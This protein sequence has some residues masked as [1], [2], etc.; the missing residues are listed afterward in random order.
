MIILIFEIGYAPAL[1]GMAFL[2]V[3][4]PCQNYFASEI[5]KIRRQ[6]I[7]F[8]DERVK[9]I[10]ESLQAIRVIKL[11]A[12]E[13]PIE[14]RVNSVREK[15]TTF[16][17]KYLDAS[18][19]LRELM[20][21]AQP[22]AA[23]VI[24]TVA[25]YGIDKPLNIVQ[26]FRVLAFLNITRL[27]LNL[28]GQALKNGSDGLVSINRLN[29]F[30]LQRTLPINAERVQV[31]NPSIHL[32]D[33]TFSWQDQVLTSSKSHDHN[34]AEASPT[35]DDKES[36]LDYF[37]LQN[38]SFSNSKPNELIAIVGPVGSGKSSLISSI[39]GEMVKVSGQ[40]RVA[41]TISYCS[42]TPWIQ[43]LTL[44]Q[45][46]L[47]EIQEKDMNEE[48][49]NKYYEATEAAALRPDIKIL[50]AGDK[51]EIGERGINLSGGQKARVSLARAFFAN[52]RSQIYLLDDPFSA[53]D[54]NTG[55]TIFQKGIM[56]LLKNKLRI[57]ALNS[58]MHLLK[59]FDRI[60]VLE[61]GRIVADGSFDVL[62]QA[63][64]ELMT[65]ITGLSYTAKDA[66]AE[67]D[68]KV[69]VAEVAGT[70]A[71]HSEANTISNQMNTMEI[72][73]PT[74]VPTIEGSNIEVIN[75]GESDANKADVKVIPFDIEQGPSSSSTPSQIISSTLNNE[76]KEK[77]STNNIVKKLVQQEKVDSGINTMVAYLKYFSA[78]LVS[79]NS[80]QRHPFYSGE[81]TTNFY[82]TQLLVFG[83]FS[84]L[85]L[86]ILFSSTQFFRIAVDYCIVKFSENFGHYGNYWQRM[87]YSSFGF[88]LFFL[89]LRSVY[90]NFFAVRSSSVLHASV[91]RRVLSAPITTFFDTHTVGAILNRFSKDME[92]VEVNIPE[93]MLQLLINWFQVFSV[94]GL[95]IWASPWF[96]IILIPLALGF[97]RVY[98][99]FSGS[100][101][102]LKRLESVSRSPIYAS[103]SETLTGLETIRAYGDHHRFLQT[104]MKRMQRNQNFMYHLYLC[105]SWMTIR[106]EFSTSMILTSVSLL[107][108]C[109]RE[110]VSPI[111]LGLALSYG[112]QLTAL[113]QRCVQLVI[114]IQTYMTS[115]ERVLEYLDKP[116][117]VNVY[118]NKEYS[119]QKIQF[120][121]QQE[122]RQKQEQQQLT[123]GVSES[124]V[125]WPRSGEIELRNVWMQYR[126]NPPV[127]KGLAAHIKSGE[128]IGVCGRT[129][130]GKVS[131]FFYF[132]G[133]S[134]I[135]F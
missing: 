20:F 64:P 92:T 10:N 108:V 43:N 82:S 133:Q 129:G 104:H 106:L 14:N 61:E 40:C 67:G 63:N 22:V 72:H 57:I 102:D 86:L 31:E 39:L 78:S 84:G 30:L 76:G 101:R 68:I 52:Y 132:S 19:R 75:Q 25:A 93:F 58:H 6:M 8:T 60:L 41:G 122:E 105:S 109:L 89:L 35:S 16:L 98:S 130:A 1:V 49:L 71:E 79:V 9:L 115:T 87:Y 113:F 120:Q 65:R 117:E 11:Y 48:Q 118:P 94:F 59:Y 34:I 131:L 66:A 116:Q 53:V 103:L 100:S 73:Q 81:K 5:G 114:E 135:T 126:D 125:Y 54:G 15:E 90:L 4:F 13:K 134:Q 97:Y 27:P 55:N 69:E 21:S 124:T 17:R 2:F 62:F 74:E 24:V 26:I 107:S 45:N 18:A 7:K 95:C 111:S 42:Q 88:L 56:Q 29:A 36:T 23:L 83:F 51:T 128:R 28:L 112:L 44:Q 110:S 96:V 37:R 50:P 12:W 121:R 47:F 123:T 38:I 70:P 119:L 127:L 3:L 80:I 32:S 99:Y 85:L 91:L 46:V 33:A 77:S